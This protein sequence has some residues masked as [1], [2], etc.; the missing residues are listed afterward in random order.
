MINIQIIVYGLLT[1]LLYALL[2]SG[3]ALVYG[4]MKI[5]NLAHGFFYTMGAFLIYL[6]VVQ[7]GF[8]PAISIL[9]SIAFAFVFGM[10]FEKFFIRQVK[11]IRDMEILTLA[12]AMFGENLLQAIYGP[13]YRFV[14]YYIEGVWRV[15]GLYLEFQRVLIVIVT[16]AMFAGLWF[17][18]SKTDFGRSMRATSQDKEAAGLIGIDVERV[19]LVALGISCSAAAAAGIFLAPLGAIYPAMG[20]TPLVRAFTV[21]IFG[22]MGSYK[23]ALVAGLILGF[24]ETLFG[25]Y[26]FP[27]ISDIFLFAVILVVLLVRP[28]GLF[29]EALK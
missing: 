14:P 21:V 24:S 28:S 20:W 2:S 15:S 16:I 26:I 19:N 6:M 1:G 27:E 10:V 9:L 7:M 29:G 11:G 12:V 25:Y 23:G 8:H 22:G 5:I 18:I 17:F 3:Y 13:F 4:T